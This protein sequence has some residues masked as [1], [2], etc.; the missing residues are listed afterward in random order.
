MPEEIVARGLRLLGALLPAAE[1]AAILLGA[2]RWRRGAPR[3]V[4]IELLG[5]LRHAP[6]TGT[7][8]VLLDEG[9]GEVAGTAA[10]ALG[11]INGTES[12]LV[13][14]LRRRQTEALTDV[15]DA[16]GLGAS[17]SAVPDLLAVLQDAS[18]PSRLRQAARDAVRSIQARAAGA[19]AGQVA[20]AEAPDPEGSL[21]LVDDEAPRGALALTDATE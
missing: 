10:R 11:Q 12:V 21:S 7:L 20:I 3:L 8:A 5:S 6:A 18:A 17:V 9:D 4:A 16:L 14:A 1:A 15:V 2:A 13:R 19:S